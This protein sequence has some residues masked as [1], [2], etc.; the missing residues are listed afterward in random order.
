MFCLIHTAVTWLLRISVYQCVLRGVDRISG[1]QK[2]SKVSSLL[3]VLNKTTIQLTFFFPVYQWVLR[4]VDPALPR[5]M[6][7]AKYWEVHA[8]QQ[9]TATTHCNN[10]LQQRTATMH[11]NNTLQHWWVTQIIGIYTQYNTLQQHTATTHRNNTL[12]HTW[13]PLIDNVSF[14]D[15]DLLNSVLFTQFPTQ[16]DCSAGFSE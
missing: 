5:L 1:R 15:V 6:D 7:D 9:Y 11:S 12:Q 10:T 2:F 4:G 13:C 14:W 3:Y 8:L 16:N